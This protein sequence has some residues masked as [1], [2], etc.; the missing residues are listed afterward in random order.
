MNGA[1]LIEEERQRQKDRFSAE[2]DANY[3]DGQLLDAALSYVYGA[4]NVGHP[5]MQTPPKEWPWDKSWW[6]PG[7]RIRCLTKAGALIAAEI[8]R[9]QHAEVDD[10]ERVE[11]LL[12]EL[13]EK[14]KGKGNPLLDLTGGAYGAAFEDAARIV[15]KVRASGFPEEWEEEITL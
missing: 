1:D 5:S 9:I 8:D 11:N 7:D 12:L 6:K 14:Y 4:I 13:S 10:W 2:K 15:A 3:S